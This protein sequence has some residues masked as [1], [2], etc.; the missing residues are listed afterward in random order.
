MTETFRRGKTMACPHCGGAVS[1]GINVE[2]EGDLKPLSGHTSE[3]A[4]P[5]IPGTAASKFTDSER[6]ALDSAQRTG[7]LDAFRVAQLGTRP[8]ENLPSDMSGLFLLFFK[9]ATPKAIPGF[10]LEHFI[11]E[12]SPAMIEVWGAEGVAAI[13][14]DRRIKAFVPYKLLRGAT[15]TGVGRSGSKVRMDADQG[16]FQE[17]VRTKHGYVPTGMKVFFQTIQQKSKGDFAR[18]V[19]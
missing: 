3:T 7:L 14:A 10:A 1:V 18:L 19:Q 17:W 5:I 6:E 12:F 16:A 13:L 8:A 2:L 15:I 4:T 9:K 11:R